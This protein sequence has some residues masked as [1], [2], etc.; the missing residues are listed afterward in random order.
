MLKGVWG[1]VGRF[2]VSLGWVGWSGVREVW[3][4]WGRAVF[5]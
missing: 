3:L 1:L 2:G 4:G 5:G